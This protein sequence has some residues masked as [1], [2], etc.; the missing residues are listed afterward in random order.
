MPL[1]TLPGAIPRNQERLKVAVLDEICAIIDE[2]VVD[3]YEV[4]KTIDELFGQ[5]D[6]DEEVEIGEEEKRPAQGK[7]E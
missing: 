3:R 1:K 7:Q 6:D 5:R 4:K 2:P